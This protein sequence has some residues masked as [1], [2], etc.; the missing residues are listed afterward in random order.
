MNRA[1]IATALALALTCSASAGGAS[2][3][4][5]FEAGRAA[6]SKARGDDAAPERARNVILFVGDGM[7]VSTV[8]AARIFAGQQRGEPG[9]ENRLAFERFP[10][11]ALAKTY[12]T[13][14]Q[15]PDSAGTISALV[16]GAK[17][18]AGVLSVNRSVARGDF[19]AV[20][21][22]ELRTIVER[23]EERGLA[24]GF[25][26]TTTVTHATPGALYAHSPDRGW[27]ND[28]GG[29]TD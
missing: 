15:T 2:D 16:T 5:T 9:E 19:E 21:G 13:N 18:R 25:V 14:Q 22:N 24:T 23:A 20:G 7:G 1:W 4:T 11:L 27:E 8:T 28:A 3:P 29:K 17:T 10:S 6:V 12:N 26:T